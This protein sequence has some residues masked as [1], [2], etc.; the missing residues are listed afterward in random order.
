MKRTASAAVLALTLSAL[1]RPPVAAAE[2]RATRPW[3]D[4]PLAF[5]LNTPAE[6]GVDVAL[7]LRVVGQITG[8]SRASEIAEIRRLGFPESEIGR[9]APLFAADLPILPPAETP[10]EALPEAP[11]PPAP[12]PASRRTLDGEQARA[13][14]CL[15]R[16]AAC[17]LGSGCIAWASDPEASG[18]EMTHQ[19]AWLVF[20]R[21]RGCSAGL[22]L[23]ALGARL[24]GRLLGE[25][26]V[27][28]TYSETHL[29]RLATLG[30]LGYADRFQPAWI[31]TV[32]EAR[33][34]QGCWGGTVGAPCHPHPT[35][36]ALW[37]LALAERAHRW[38]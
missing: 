20:V 14:T 31:R 22:D 30:Q 35:V 27:D 6:F 34:Q 10:V 37:T 26:A 11:L 18:L 2:S 3:L 15:E 32:L 8:D 25:L 29:E 4:A 36:L 13:G 12:S 21:W 38:P 9:L 16:A 33:T 24:A 17:E 28:S 5:L 19:A 1:A 7:L 23:D